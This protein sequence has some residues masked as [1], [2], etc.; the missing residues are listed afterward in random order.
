MTNQDTW[1]FTR[2]SLQDEILYQ[3]SL[4]SIAS[5]F[6]VYKPLTLRKDLKNLTKIADILARLPDL[7]EI[8]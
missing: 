4:E 1:I 7:V 2:Y 6:R 8:I 3:T 5:C